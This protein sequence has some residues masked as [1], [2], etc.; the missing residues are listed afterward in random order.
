M[1]ICLYILGLLTVHM[2]NVTETMGLKIQTLLL[3]QVGQQVDLYR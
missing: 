1:K 3:H 2:F